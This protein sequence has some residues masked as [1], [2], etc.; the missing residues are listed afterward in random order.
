[1]IQP[2]VVEVNLNCELRW[3][4]RLYLPWLFD[5]EHSFHIEPIGD[6]AVRF[7]QSERFSGLLVPFG[8]R[9]LSNTLKGFEE[10]NKALKQR[11]EEE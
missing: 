2:T 11:A 8:G 5:G 6:K 1:M 7:V 3:L 9:L 4:G 10:M